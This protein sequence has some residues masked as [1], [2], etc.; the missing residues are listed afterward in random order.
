M[1]KFKYEI[2]Y[3]IEAENDEQAQERFWLLIKGEGDDAWM[4]NEPEFN[5]GEV[6]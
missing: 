1:K 2:S 4:A 3:V 6:V 5:G